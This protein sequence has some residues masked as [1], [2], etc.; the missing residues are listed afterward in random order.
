MRTRSIGTEA[1]KRPGVDAGWRVPFA[2]QRFRPRATQ[3]VLGQSQRIMK[4]RFKLI[5][6]A[7]FLCI[8]SFVGAITFSPPPDEELASHEL[9]IVAKWNPTNVVSRS[10]S[11]WNVRLD[12]FEQQEYEAITTIEV[13]RTLKGD[14]KPGLHL[15][16][17]PLYG[18]SFHAIKKGHGPTLYFFG[19]S[20]RP[21]AVEDVTVPCLWCLN[22]AKSWM[23][24]DTNTYP[25]LTSLFGVQPLSK[26]KLFTELMS[27][28]KSSPTNG[29]S[30]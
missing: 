26:E 5:V 11:Q 15:I 12:G 21:G 3:K 25:S 28:A 29:L 4:T 22:N 24:E 13:I 2:F 10:K 30:R 16:R 9:V 1:N 18:V 7:G 17:L 20:E 6:V 23:I 14:L 19:S 8:A 27:K